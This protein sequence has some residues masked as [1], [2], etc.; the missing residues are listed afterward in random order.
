MILLYMYTNKKFLQAISEELHQM[1]GR[2]AKQTDTQDLFQGPTPSEVN[3]YMYKNVYVH[4]LLSKIY[5]SYKF[6]V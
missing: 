6:Y 3:N 4:V 1:E 5:T 2:R